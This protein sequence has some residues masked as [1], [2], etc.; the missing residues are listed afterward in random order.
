MGMNSNLRKVGAV[1][2]YLKHLNNAEKAREEWELRMKTGLCNRFM[3]ANT[4]LM[5][6][7]WKTLID[8]NKWCISQEEK[9]LRLMKRVCNALTNKAFAEQ[10][11]AMNALKAW[12]NL[13]LMDDDKEKA[14]GDLRAGLLDGMAKTKEK[15]MR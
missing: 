2:L 13:A 4:R 12:K 10:M 1:L 15:F 11:A 3:N 8:F 14:I 6:A 9:E 5:G 7:G